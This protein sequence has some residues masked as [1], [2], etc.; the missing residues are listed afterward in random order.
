MKFKL[1]ENLPTR[2]VEVL[3][4][5]G[6]DAV[7]LLDQ[8][9]AGVRDAVV[10]QLARSEG[11]ALIT[12]DL[13]FADIRAYQPSDYSGLIVLRPRRTAGDDILRLLTR[14]TDAVAREP[15]EGCLWIV[16]EHRIRILEQSS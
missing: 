9:A 13:D 16:D 4:A 15:L 12:L 2:A 1:D 14:L 3:R 7:H 6:H 8:V 11:R 10:A 5:A